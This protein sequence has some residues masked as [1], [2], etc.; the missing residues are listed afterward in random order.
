MGEEDVGEIKRKSDGK[1][2]GEEVARQVAEVGL[3]AADI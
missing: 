2:T 1:K 3:Q